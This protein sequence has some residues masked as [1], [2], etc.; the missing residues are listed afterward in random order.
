VR[1]SPPSP[2]WELRAGAEVELG[3]AS[4]RHLGS[5][6]WHFEESRGILLGRGSTLGDSEI[7]RLSIAVRVSFRSISETFWAIPIDLERPIGRRSALGAYLSP[8]RYT[9]GSMC[10]VSRNSTGHVQ[11][12][13]VHNEAARDPG[14]DQGPLVVEVKKSKQVDIMMIW[15]SCANVVLLS[16]LQRGARGVG[17]G[18]PKT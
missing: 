1:H 7:R 18:R 11:L 17:K 5:P 16:L 9:S 14:L 15:P 2:S 4:C 12:S 6:N 8:E 3:E 13:L 10:E